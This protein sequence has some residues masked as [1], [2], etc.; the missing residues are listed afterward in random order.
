[1]LNVSIVT[2]HT[3]TDELADCLR[4]LD[5]PLVDHIYVVDNA[6]DAA[7]EKFCMRH[8]KVSYISS[9]NGGYGAGHNQA[10]VKSL[11]STVP[12]HLVLNS[13]VSFNPSVLAA[14]IK[15]ME[16]NVDVALIHPRLRYPDGRE[17]LTA[18]LLP[19]PLDVFSRR[20]LPAF[21]FRA[22]DRRYTLAWT[23]RSA[24]MDVPYVQGSFMLMRCAALRRV[25]LFDTRFFM[26]PEDIDLTRR[27]HRH[28]RTLYWPDIEAVHKH[29]A[30]S[31]ANLRMLW[32]HS[33]N[34][35]RYFN[36]W[37]WFFDRE[38]RRMNRRLVGSLK[39]EV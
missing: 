18:R 39:S 21:M 19:T 9:R 22:R 37:G 12:F 30:S 14:A 23:D 6:A 26:Y 7:M 20:F 27:L 38:R 10:L 32:I 11:D 15:F 5:S 17:Q 29:R 28:Y 36:K 33:R 24:A 1:M 34:M 31:Y 25:G 35:I 2:Y 4:S 13:D 16:D 3:D 8:A